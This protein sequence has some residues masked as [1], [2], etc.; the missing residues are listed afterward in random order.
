MLLMHQWLNDSLFTDMS[1]IVMSFSTQNFNRSK[2]HLLQCFSKGILAMFCL[3]L[4]FPSYGKKK[5]KVSLRKP[6]KN[7]KV[8]DKSI[9]L[10]TFITVFY[11]SIWIHKRTAMHISRTHALTQ[12]V[13]SW[14]KQMLI[15]KQE[16]KKE[17]NPL[18]LHMKS[19]AIGFRDQRLSLWWHE[20]RKI[21]YFILPPSTV[22]FFLQRSRMNVP[23]QLLLTPASGGS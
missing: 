4:L 13:T 21:C 1:A 5:K 23:L 3:D 19:L 18:Q 16:K 8:L 14:A 2:S 11:I 12:I 15:L 20:A 6:R 22:F 9:S 17:K 10:I 7:K